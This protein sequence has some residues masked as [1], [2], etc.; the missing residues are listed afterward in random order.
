MAFIFTIFCL[1]IGFALVTARFGAQLQERLKVLNMDLTLRKVLA[2]LKGH[3]SGQAHD[4]IAAEKFQPQMPLMS[5]MKITWKHTKKSW[6]DTKIPPSR[7]AQTMSS[8]AW[9]TMVLLLL[10]TQLLLITKIQMF[11]WRIS[12]ERQT[13]YWMV[14]RKGCARSMRLLVRAAT[15]CPWMRL[16]ATWMTAPIYDI[17]FEHCLEMERYMPWPA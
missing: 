14:V 4:E 13:A 7:S 5:Q 3:G 9:S 17:R 15:S 1:F 12:C 6:R 2:M 11:T 8:G 10:M 16:K